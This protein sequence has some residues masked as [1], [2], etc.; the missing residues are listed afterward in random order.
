MPDPSKLGLDPAILKKVSAYTAEIETWIQSLF[1]LGEN[2]DGW[3]SPVEDPAGVLNRWHKRRLKNAVV[4]ADDVFAY[5]GLRI[6]G[7]SWLPWWSS[8]PPDYVNFGE[9]GTGD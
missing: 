7:S 2:A 4:L 9:H 5:Y 1:C 6:H 3:D 8:E